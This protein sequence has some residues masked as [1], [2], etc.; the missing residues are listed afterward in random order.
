MPRILGIMIAALLFAAPA[1]AIEPFPATFKTQHIAVNGT[2]LYVRVGGSGPAVVMLH[3]FG[4]TGDM[5]A[6]AAVV[7]AR[8]HTVVV[9]DLRGMG[10]SA[11][12]DDG[13]TKK[14]Q[15][16]DIAGVMDA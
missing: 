15:A 3:G 16:V 12:P 5:W 14:N 2:T 6:P 4:D 9:P 1:F 7:L 13:Y 8:T 11:H 10:L